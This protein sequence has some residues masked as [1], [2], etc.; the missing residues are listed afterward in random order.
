MLAPWLRNWSEKLLKA[1]IPSS[2][3]EH[4]GVLSP[5]WAIRTRWEN[6][7]EGVSQAL[8]CC[9]ECMELVHLCP[10]INSHPVDCP[11]S[12]HG[13]AMPYSP[14]RAS[15]FSNSP[16]QPSTPWFFLLIVSWRLFPVL[17]TWLTPTHLSRSWSLSSLS[18]TKVMIHIVSNEFIL[19]GG[20]WRGHTWLWFNSWAPREPNT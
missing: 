8:R 12:H 14:Q 7:Y 5:D 16:F 2:G 20:W 1:S 18:V 15:G 19:V 4:P 11:S 10:P 9:T 13:C 3:D 17:P 6:G